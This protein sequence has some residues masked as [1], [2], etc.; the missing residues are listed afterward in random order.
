MEFRLLGSVEV[1]TE[2]RAVAAGGPKQRALLAIL[3]LDANR[4]VSRDRLVDGLWGERPPTS[5]DHTLDALV[6]RLRKL[7]GSDRL[8]R[9]GQG[10][11]LVVAPG[12]LDLERFESRANEGIEAL[13]AG[14]ARVAHERLSSALEEWHGDPLEDVIAEPF[15]A[16][17]A[18]RLDERRLVVAEKRI[19]AALALGASAELVPELEQL[20]RAHPF[21]ERVV[22]H[23]ALALHRAGRSADALALLAEARRR[24]ASELGLELAPALKDLELKILR[25]DPSLESPHRAVTARPRRRRRALLLVAALAAA[26]GATAVVAATFLTGGPPRAADAS[27]SQLAEVG[28]GRPVSIA[29][30][31]PL[32]T[33]D[34]AVWVAEPNESLV[35][36]VDPASRSVVDRIPVD[37]TPTALAAGRHALWVATSVPGAVERIDYETDQVTQRIPLGVTPVALGVTRGRIWVADSS[38]QTLI[39]LDPASGAATATV[40]LGSHPSALVTS[41]STAWVVSHDD[42]TLTE[43]DLGSGAP[44]ATTTLGVGPSGVA[45][46]GGAVLVSNDLAGTVTRVDPASMAVTATIGTGSG[47]SGLVASGG[48]VWVANR[49]SRTLSRVDIASGRIVATHAAAGAPVSVVSVSGRLWTAMAPLARHRG[50]RL[51]LLAQG[52][53]RSMDPQIEYEVFPPQL[54]GLAYDALLTFDHT[55]GSEGLRIVPDLAVAVPTPADGGRTY[56]LR[57]RAGIRYADGRVVEATDFRRTFERL[58]RVGSPI[59]PAFAALVGSSS[60]SRQACDLRRAVTVDARRRTIVFHLARPDPEFLFK[61]TYVFTAPVPPGTAM[62]ALNTKPYPGTGPYRIAAASARGIRLLRNRFFH[63]WSHAAQ[64]AG[65]P[66]EI[67]WRFGLS[68]AQQVRAIRAG[69]ADWSYDNVPVDALTRLRRDRPGDLHASV[70]PETDFVKIDTR[71]HPFDDVRVRRALNFALDRRRVVALYG[72]AAR[73]TCQVLPP[74]VPGFRP[75][76]PYPHD[77]ARA[78]RLVRAA[79]AAGR[80]VVIIGY[81]DDATIHRSV[82]LYLASVVKALGFRPRIVWTTHAA[83]QGTP[84]GALEAVG[85][86]ADYP[87][88]SDFFGT[89]IACNGAFNEGRFCEPQLDRSIRAASEAEAVDPRRAA[90]LWAATDR[91]TVDAAAWVPLANPTLFDYT[92]AR[93]RGYQHHL[94]WGFLA[95]QAWLR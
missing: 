44:V 39:G 77:L 67:A 7:I 41:G 2:G 25:H 10:Y 37:G 8:R 15:A 87:A 86:Y 71:E 28:H 59:V 62:T 49:Y 52:P 11:R 19:E 33:A 91:Q 1:S 73:P 42:G 18:R 29:D 20:A 17:A 89:F 40:S 32:A 6:S 53:F 13:A 46:G 55:G 81:T 72:D 24:L 63:E 36:R 74:G 82:V 43:V 23:L 9:E 60:C 51:V 48:F 38:D 26:A 5:A 61:L 66:D 34:G 45:L 64:P 57:L 75:Y 65:N 27:T 35:L 14:D 56:S 76:C 69:R 58:F 4:A 92:S 93:V 54:H 78:R 94:V 22:G 95:D 47:A 3:L 70:E 50:G 12:E 90:I 88:A 16:E 83:Y 21:R 84:A 79:H 30:A 80:R 68:P 31:G 85:W